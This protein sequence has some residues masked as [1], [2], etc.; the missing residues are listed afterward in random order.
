MNKTLKIGQKVFFV[1]ENQ[2]YMVKALTENFAVCVRPLHVRE[3]SKFIFEYAK[4]EEI[5]FSKAFRLM[6]DSPVYTL[7]D[8]SKNERGKSNLLF[9]HYNYNND[10][11]CWLVIQMLESGVMGLSSRN[12]IELN[13]NWDKT[14]IIIN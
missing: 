3:D 9:D 10:D 6:K 7:I 14:N 12:K 4:R 1:N 2:S 13:I 11:E 5:S 8:F